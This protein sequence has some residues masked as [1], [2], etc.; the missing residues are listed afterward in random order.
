MSHIEI[1]QL[2]DSYV[3]LATHII[4]LIIAYRK[5]IADLSRRS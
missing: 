5:L 1:V 4:F 3:V 2:I